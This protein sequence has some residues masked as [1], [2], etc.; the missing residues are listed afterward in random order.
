MMQTVK[1]KWPTL[2]IILIASV[3]ISLSLIQWTDWQ[4]PEAIRLG[5]QLVVL[6]FLGMLL[7]HGEDAK[8]QLREMVV[9]NEKALDTALSILQNRAQ[10]LESRTTAVA[11]DLATSTAVTAQKVEE[12]LQAIE[13][14][15]EKSISVSIKAATASA[16]AAHVA[17]SV[18][19]KIAALGQKIQ[20]VE[21]KEEQK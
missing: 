7:Q 13:N 14:R 5:V 18:N 4:T 19:E 16:E 15:L 2:L 6:G 3:G 1:S 17:N 9:M 11:A 10:E 8:R 12:Y 21:L 20:I